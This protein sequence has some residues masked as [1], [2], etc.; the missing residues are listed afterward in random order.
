MSRAARRRRIASWLAAAAAS[1]IAFDAFVIEPYALEITRHEARA[2]VAARL[3][4]AHVSD[5]HTGG[6]G[7]RERALLAALDEAKPDLIAI[8]GDTVDG[9]DLEPARELLVAMTTKAPLGVVAVHGNWEHWRPVS[10]AERFYAEV[11]VRFLRNDAVRVRDD[12]WVVGLDDDLAGAP[13]ATRAFAKVPPGRTPIVIFHSP[14]AV[15]AIAGRAPIALAG[16]THAGQVRLPLL[17]ALW[18]PPGSGRFDHGWYE[19]SGT[20]LFVSRGV[21]TSLLPVRFW[22]RPELALITLGP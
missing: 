9:G 2:P 12:L 21:G 4:I 22:C 13:D 8:T 6:L 11:G 18:R 3:R 1:L 17:G 20:R 10:D 15:D 7:R 16:H 19:A 14:V 5:L